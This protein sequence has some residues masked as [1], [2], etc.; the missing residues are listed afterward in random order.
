[1]VEGGEEEKEKGGRD[2]SVDEASVEE[3]RGMSQRSS[4]QKWVG[5]WTRREWGKE[6]TGRFGSM[7][8]GCGMNN[9]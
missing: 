8:Y 7:R 5:V 1:L 2:A 3:I 9:C 6:G 4:L